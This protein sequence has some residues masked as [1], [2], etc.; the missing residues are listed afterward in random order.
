M[1]GRSR[2]MIPGSYNELRIKW[3]V[4]A[5][6]PFANSQD[7]IANNL[8]TDTRAVADIID[9]PKE[10]DFPVDQMMVHLLRQGSLCERRS[11]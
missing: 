3:R 5:I 8:L 1:A 10:V 4:N 7:A 9:M 6:S 2:Q 11:T